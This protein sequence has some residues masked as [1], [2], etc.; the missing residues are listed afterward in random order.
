MKLNRSKQWWLCQWI[1]IY[2]VNDYFVLPTIFKCDIT[3][4]INLMILK[5]KCTHHFTNQRMKPSASLALSCAIRWIKT[6]GNND[7]HIIRTYRQASELHHQIRDHF[8]DRFKHTSS[9]HVDWLW[10]HRGPCRCWFSKVVATIIKFVDMIDFYLRNLFQRNIV[11]WVITLYRGKNSLA[12][13]AFHSH[14]EGWIYRSCHI[15]FY[16]NANIFSMESM[17]TCGL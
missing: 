2:I 17:I 8:P 11:L 16:L 7:R 14:F 3:F 12:L 1:I 10:Q 5:V 4:C 13:G 15:Q 6:N 9:P